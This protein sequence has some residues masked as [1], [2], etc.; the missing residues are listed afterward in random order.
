[1]A[2][3]NDLGPTVLT[4]GIV[5]VSALLLSIAYPDRYV[6]TRSRPDL[7]GPKGAPIVGN[8]L[9]VIP[10]HRRMLGWFKQLNENYG[11]VATFTLPPWGRGILINRPEW[12]L[13]VKQADIQKYSRGPVARALFKEFPGGKTPVASEGAGW[14]LARKSMY[15]IFTVKSFTEH[16]SSAMNTIVPT[17]RSFLLNASKKNIPVDWNDLA[18]RIA[19]SIFSHSAFTHDTGTLTSDPSIQG[20]DDLRNALLALNLI[21]ARRLFNPFWQWT[22]YI[23]G[24]RFRFNR[25]RSYIRNIVLHMI[26]ARRAEIRDVP[27]GERHADFLTALLEDPTFDD[28]ILIRDTLV[29]LLFA[30]RDNT[31]NVLAWGLHALMGAPQWMDRMREE[32]T[33]NGSGNHELQYADLS[34]YPVHLAVFYETVRLWPGLPKNARLALCDDVLPALPEHGIA[35]V[36]IEKGDYIFWS[37]HNMMRDEAVWGPNSNTFDP[38]RHLTPDGSFVRPAQPRFNGFGAG[39]R[40][41]PAAQLATYEFVATMAGILPFFDL[42]P[43][44]VPGLYDE[45]SMNESFTSSL[46]GPLWIDIRMRKGMD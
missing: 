6:T 32:V 44:K 8:L 25:A 18:G 17:A 9:Q 39:P 4:A 43:S 40:L 33:R 31:Q 1:M 15:P 36:K 46:A 34:R 14:R 41:C 3:L 2:A 35:A 27:A 29:T 13:Y 16:V 28:P 11:P 5:V 20:S 42:E 23:T 22:E 19:L 7:I 24:D 12:L 26:E 21:S 38:S 10:R 45:P 37:D 30:G